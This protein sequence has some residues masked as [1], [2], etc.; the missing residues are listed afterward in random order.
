MGAWIMSYFLR[1]KRQQ[2]D[3]EV[4]QHNPS[5]WTQ[6]T[7]KQKQQHVSKCGISSSKLQW[8]GSML[9]D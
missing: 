6:T 8:F 7:I 4:Y 9:K 2:W 1:V 5:D 3:I